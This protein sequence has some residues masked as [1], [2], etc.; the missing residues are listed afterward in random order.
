[1]LEQIV[2]VAEQAVAAAVGPSAVAD[3]L[4]ITPSGVS[5]WVS[6]NRV[7][8]KRVV[9]LCRLTG[10]VFQPHQIRPDVFDVGVRV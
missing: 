1:M 10:G 4:G 6:A 7:P 5:Q 3:E 2:N 9:P 8:K